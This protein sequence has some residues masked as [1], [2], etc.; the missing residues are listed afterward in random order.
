MKH[1]IAVINFKD[2]ERTLLAKAISCMSGYQFVQNRNMYEWMNLFKID[3]GKI[4]S[5]ENQ[6]LLLSSSFIKRIKSEFRTSDFISNGSAFTEVLSLK[7]KMNE[8]SVEMNKPE[9]MAMIKSLLNISGRYAAQNYDMIIHV[10]NTDSMNFDELAIRFYEK[11]H[12]AYKLYD[13]S[14]NMQNLVENII[15]EVEMPMVQS[16]ESAIYEAEQ[17]VNFKT[18]KS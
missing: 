16:V 9:E 13:G 12:I 3:E 7:S 4:Y 11:Y 8:K 6:F 5:F 1:K 15:R 10:K 18:W 14:N 17:L 2:T